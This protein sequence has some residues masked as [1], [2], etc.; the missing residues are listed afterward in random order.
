M[1][2]YEVL[3]PAPQTKAGKA[4]CTWL[5][6]RGLDSTKSYV[7][8]QLRISSQGRMGLSGIVGGIGASLVLWDTSLDREVRLRS[9]PKT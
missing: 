1:Y 9:P 6:Q 4:G 7:A 2:F 8:T 3:R 5:S